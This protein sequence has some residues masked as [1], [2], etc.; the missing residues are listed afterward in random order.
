MRYKHLPPET[1]AAIDQ[2][3]R[4]SSNDF[5]HEARA[6]LRPDWSD[7]EKE[8][9]MAAAARRIWAAIADGVVEHI[10][11]FENIEVDEELRRDLAREHEGYFVDAASW[12]DY[13]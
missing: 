1:Q 10:E 8:Q 13:D 5:V 2:A 6:E 4:D 9:H 11:R 3:L 7:S 12:S